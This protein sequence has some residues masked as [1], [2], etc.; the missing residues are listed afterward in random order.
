MKKVIR[1]Y[2]NIPFFGQCYFEAGIPLYKKR[3]YSLNK[4]HNEIVAEFPLGEIIF[5]PRKL[6]TPEKD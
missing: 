1:F 4:W 5:T 3:L 6:L 2:L